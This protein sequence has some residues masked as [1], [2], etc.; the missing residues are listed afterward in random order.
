MSADRLLVVGGGPAGVTAALQ[1]RELG[2]QVTLLEAGQVGGTSL[3]QGPGPARLRTLPRAPRLARDWSS[4]ATFGLDGPR[5]VPDLPAVVANSERVARYAHDRKDL[6]G[7]LRRH[8]I[9]L[10]EGLGPVG[11]PDPHTL[12]R[13]PRRV[14]A[15]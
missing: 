3:N 11:F 1:A 10:I 8:G 14:T 4:W 13:A 6:A 7:H 12:T 15:D 2:A 9:D 5:P